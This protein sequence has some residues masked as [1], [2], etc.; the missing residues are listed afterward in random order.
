MR[1]SENSP[2]GETNSATMFVSSR[3]LTLLDH[4]RT[5]YDVDAELA[6]Q[7]IGALRPASG[8]PALL[9][10]ATCADSPSVTATVLGADGETQIPLFARM[11]SAQA[12]EPMLAR[13]GGDWLRA[14]TLIG[15]DGREIGAI[16]RRDDGSV[17]L[18][19]DPD[20]VLVN[21][22]SERYSAI[23][24]SP[25]VRR[26]RAGLM[27]GYYRVRPLVPRSL[28]IASRRH[29]AR[30]QAR[31]QFP[32]WPVETCVDDFCALI[33]AILKDIVGDPVP[34]IAP[35]PRRHAWALVLTHDVEGADG[36]AAIEP[37]LELERAHGIRSSWNFVPRRYDVD[38]QLLRELVTDGFEV[39]VHGLHHDGRDLASL[40][41]WRQR[42]PAINEAGQRWGAAGF[43]SPALHRHWDWMPLLDFEYDSSSPDTD[44]FEPQAGGCCTWLPFFN[45][46]I[47]E[48]PVTL[49]Q[50]HTLFVILRH[51]DERA[52][53][54]KTCFLRDHSGMA[55][56]DTHPDYLVEDRILQAY[57]RFLEQFAHDPTAWKAL[58]R[59]V[60][61]WWRRR[62][63]S[64]LQ[65]GDEGWEI[66]GP[67]A[68]EARI[69]MRGE[70][71]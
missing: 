37:V 57:A 26:L 25:N 51:E 33:F 30:L 47:V 42:V 39:G 9:W 27:R 28:Q 63:A 22:W 60:S 5:P 21:Y 46:N 65:Y 61:S 35:W 34:S 10:P 38:S 49:A 6:D 23:S 59:D 19:F 66:V 41:K 13:R 45:H 17:F 1:T 58:P 53:V 55:L 40:A 50:D 64:S 67:A 56:L 20:E 68:D 32:R 15:T 43:R 44:P 8:G 71:W 36:L 52:W 7:G 54:R 70:A 48:L 2:A 24:S 62:A 31:A 18:P 3:R 69:E 14:R 4:F 11:A 12:I 16:W 29:L